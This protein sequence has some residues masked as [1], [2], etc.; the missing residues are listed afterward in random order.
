MTKGKLLL[1]AIGLGCLAAVVLAA[2]HHIRANGPNNR[3]I[4]ACYEEIKERIATPAT[5]RAARAEVIDT[6]MTYQDWLGDLG[7]TPEAS[8]ARR[9][10]VL[11][12][13]GHSREE[14][15]A[16]QKSEVPQNPIRRSIVVDYDASNLMGALVRSTFS[17]DYYLKSASQQ[18]EEGDLLGRKVRLH[19]E[20]VSAST[21]QAIER[22]QET[23]RALQRL[24]QR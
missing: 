24:Q 9:I 3:A 21:Q 14:A 13:I 19:A 2:V 12:M 16:Q 8:K 18:I 10:D 15:E 6:P 23:I 7:S 20:R 22:T 5:F 17:C 1:L 11:M 4:A